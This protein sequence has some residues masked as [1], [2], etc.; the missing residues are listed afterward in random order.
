MN[1]SLKKILTPAERIQAVVRMT[2]RTQTG[3]TVSSISRSL[4]ISR[5]HLHDL[6]R[7]FEEDP[8]MSDR[9]RSGCLP[10]VTD[11]LERRIIREIENDPFASSVSL[12]NRVNSGLPESSQIAVQNV[13]RARRPALKPSITEKQAKER[14]AFA[15]KY[16]QKD[17]RFW[18]HVIF[19]DET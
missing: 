1:E 13:L 4:Q 8:S 14:L 15:Q 19:S 10:K 18:S 17:M 9:E 7:K 11:Q 12:T 6:E 5:K 2:N 3:E 16:A